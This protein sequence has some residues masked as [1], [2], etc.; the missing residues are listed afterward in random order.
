LELPLG[1]KLPLL[2][3]ALILLVLLA[4]SGAAYL[5]VER[6]A[7]TIAKERVTALAR[8]LAEL[9]RASV[10]ARSAIMRRVTSDTAVRRLLRSPGSGA[11]DVSSGVSAALERLV[12]PSDSAGAIEVWDHAGHSR[13]RYAA[14]ITPIE[15]SADDPQRTMLASRE[16]GGAALDS[17]RVGPFYTRRDSVY[18]WYVLPVVDGGLVSGFVAQRIKLE[19]NA[20]SI[21]ARRG[22]REIMGPGIDL[23]LANA[24]NDC[25][26]RPPDNCRCNH[27][28]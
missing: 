23:F 4:A 6:S 16:S 10:V 26:R 3:S 22:L 20:S 13:A 11:L 2:I 15:D 8:Q 7:T 9:T 1:R 25:G 12:V 19:R 24:D 17:I 27:R 5:E 21:S 28:T 14:G 18:T